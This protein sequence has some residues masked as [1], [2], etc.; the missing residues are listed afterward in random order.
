[1]NKIYQKKTLLPK[2]PAKSI[3]GGFTLIELLVVVLIIGIL[4]A[5][6]LPQYRFAV[7]K[8]RTARAL[9]LL[10]SLRDAQDRYFMANGKYAYR[11]DDLDI[12]LSI[13]K[14]ITE[15]T[16]NST[17]S[18]KDRDNVA[19]LIDSNGAVRMDIGKDPVQE[20]IYIYYYPAN[21]NP[22]RECFAATAAGDNSPSNKLC[23]SLGGVLLRTGTQ[24]GC[25]GGQ[26]CNYYSLS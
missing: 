10:K 2:T 21:R 23:K 19:Y 11:F 12:Q 22:A 5:V 14:A 7:F 26:G 4:A 13:C 18:L 6:A 3:L 20:R 16:N 15:R 17:C 25:N 1:M 9:P 8:S 24:S